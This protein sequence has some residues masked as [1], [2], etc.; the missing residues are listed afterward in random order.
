MRAQD[1]EGLTLADYA[2]DDWVARQGY[3]ELPWPRVVA[4]WEAL[5]RHLVHVI[6]RIPDTSAP[7][8]CRIGEASVTL[9]F[10]ATEYVTH[11]RHHLA[12]ILDPESAKGRAY[13]PW[14]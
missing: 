14:A 6:A 11:L 13:P 5:N 7:R 1:G 10:I 4:L 9:G 8:L 12:Q 3:G 2:Q